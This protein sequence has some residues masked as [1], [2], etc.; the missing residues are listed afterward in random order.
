MLRAPTSTFRFSWF[1]SKTSVPCVPSKF[2]TASVSPWCST[3]PLKFSGVFA[4]LALSTFKFRVYWYGVNVSVSSK[5]NG[6][7]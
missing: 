5:F 7:L 2:C 1:D 4:G 6:L 3:Y